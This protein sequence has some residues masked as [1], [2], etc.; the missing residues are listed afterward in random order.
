MHIPTYES[1]TIY[2]THVYIIYIHTY[3][4][5]YIYIYIHTRIAYIY[6]YIHIYIYTYIHTY[7]YIHI[8]IYT[9]IHVYIYAHI[10]IYIHTY[11]Y[12]HTYIY[13]YAYMLGFGRWCLLGKH[14]SL[15]VPFSYVFGGG[16]EVSTKNVPWTSLSIRSEFRFQTVRLGMQTDSGKNQHVQQPEGNHFSPSQNWYQ[17]KYALRAISLAKYVARKM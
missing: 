17:E 9:C 13:I 14:G 10:H 7:I 5:M 2:V 1:N 4:H 15:G 6:A 8:H 3:T 11:I 12:T 16:M